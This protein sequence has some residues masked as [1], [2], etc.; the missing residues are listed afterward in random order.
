[1]THF[2]HAAV[3]SLKMKLKKNSEVKKT[4]IIL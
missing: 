2:V 3:I 4:K 1:M